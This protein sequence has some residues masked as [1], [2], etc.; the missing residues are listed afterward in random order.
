M[1]A[2]FAAI[3]G[4]TG[5]KANA[6]AGCAYACPPVVVCSGLNSHKC[7][8]DSCVADPSHCRPILC[9]EGERLCGDGTC[10][11]TCDA[12]SVCPASNPVLCNDGKCVSSMRQCAPNSCDSMTCADGSCEDS[13]KQCQTKLAPKCDTTKGGKVCPDGMCVPSWSLC[14]PVPRCPAHNPLRCSDGGCYKHNSTDLCAVKETGVCEDGRAA[15]A[16][17]RTGCPPFDGCALSAPFYCPGKT[18]MCV[19]DA[20]ACD[21]QTAL[22]CK[23]DCDRDS[24]ATH[25]VFFV[26]PKND[27]TVEVSLKDNVPRSRLMIPA[28][29]YTRAMPFRV[30]PITMRQMG[31]QYARNVLSSTF[32]LGVINSKDN[33]AMRLNSTFEAAVDRA[34]YNSGGAAVQDVQES[35]VTCDLQADFSLADEKN[36]LGS[37]SIT[38]DGVQLYVR[39]QGT[40]CQ[41]KEVHIVTK[42][43]SV[44]DAYVKDTK[45]S[46]TCVCGVEQDSTNNKGQCYLA[47][48]T[49]MEV[50]LF[51]SNATETFKKNN[52][53]YFACPSDKAGVTA[54]QGD[55]K[56]KTADAQHFT[57]RITPDSADVCAVSTDSTL[58]NDFDICLG[59]VAG[60]VAP[61][62]C[63]ESRFDRSRDGYWTSEA[64]SSRLRGRFR[65]IDNSAQSIGFAK[66]DLPPPT[67]EINTAR[68]WWDDYG[69]VTTGLIFFFLF[70]FAGLGFALFKGWKYVKKYRNEKDLVDHYQDKIAEQDEFSGGLGMADA[71]DDIDMVANPLVIEMQELQ[72]EVYK[73]NEQLNGQAEEELGNIDNLELERQRLYAEIQRIK[74]E[75]A[76][77]QTTS[78]PTRVIETQAAAAPAAAAAPKAA[79]PVKHDFGQARANKKKK[80][81]F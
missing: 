46:L 23:D 18:N 32:R 12:T 76:K 73:V 63:R 34:M 33:L 30:H 70:L 75:M 67:L 64:S 71:E 48:R 28:G 22:A 35:D 49:N 26:H 81:N 61:I 36:C 55:D 80:K 51:Y 56:V 77:A 79:Q 19:K 3:A 38:A 11:A 16:D 53:T 66:V 29:A 59:K 13:L 44:V 37:A 15:K 14:G 58:I 50:K 42:H 20:A 6:T 68:T 54:E 65:L 69:G 1:K 62:G 41:S 10:N 47:K 45:E 52:I 4:F 2:K 7:G 24:A 5:T 25:Q 9:P 17:G 8:D 72:E 31:G 27:V 43:V 74:D 40:F 60:A 78:K 57:L 39:R 21:A